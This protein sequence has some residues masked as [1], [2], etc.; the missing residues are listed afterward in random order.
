MKD[1]KEKQGFVLVVV[2]ALV[3]ALILLFVPSRLEK[4]KPYSLESNHL[5]FSREAFLSLL[6]VPDSL[7][8]GWALAVIVVNG[9]ATW[10]KPCVE[11][12]PELNKLRDAYRDREDIVFLAL[13]MEDS[14]TVDSFL[15]KRGI[16]FS[17]TILA[18]QSD[19]VFQL[20]E[21]EGRKR[22]PLFKTTSIPFHMILSESD[23]ILFAEVGA[24]DTNIKRMET[25]LKRLTGRD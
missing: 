11:E 5:S 7:K 16:R 18:N 9:W 23:S 24:S 4:T 13:T 10:C 8:E 2:V 25:I 20:L 15:R 17:Y 22:N 19:A 1:L 6:N 14:T 3:C 12:I 21:E